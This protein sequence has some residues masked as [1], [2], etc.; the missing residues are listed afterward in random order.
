MS[1]SIAMSGI[2][3]V[4]QHLES[5]SNNIANSDTGGYKGTRTSFAATYA[6]TQAMGVANN[7]V[8][9]NVAEGGT[10]RKGRPLDVAIQGAGFLKVQDTNGVTGYTRGG[11]LKVDVQGNLTDLAGRKVHGYAMQP[12]GGIG[13]LGAIKIPPGSLPPVV[14]T[15]TTFMGNLD[16]DT[17]VGT[18][19]YSSANTLYDARGTAITLDHIFKVTGPNTV[20]VTYQVNSAPLQITTNVIERNGG[21]VNVITPVTTVLTFDNTGVLIATENKVPTHALAGVPDAYAVNPGAPVLDIASPGANNLAITPAYAGTTMYGGDSKASKSTANGA[22]SASNSG[23]MIDKNGQVHVSY[24]NGETTPVAT[25]AV[26][27]FANPDGLVPSEQSSW[28][29][30]SQSGDALLSPA[31]GNIISGMQ[32]GSNVDLT[33]ELVNLMTAQRNYQANTKV[34]STQNQV[35]QSLMQAI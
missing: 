5:I 4:N 3:A 21:N 15:T 24:S 33:G 17:R 31:S 32:E 34:I 12:G 23:V 18:V 28:A 8:S 26:A 22:A 27:T 7:G 13:A 19:A 16:K 14:S 20:E 30:S 1:F 35:M 6:G 25:L 2:N 9:H 10:L 11:Q 29:A